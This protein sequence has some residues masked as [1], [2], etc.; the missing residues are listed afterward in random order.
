MRKKVHPVISSFFFLAMLFSFF[1]AILLCYLGSCRITSQLKQ[2][3]GGSERRSKYISYNAFNSRLISDSGRLQVH[4]YEKKLF[5]F[6]LFFRLAS[7]QLVCSRSEGRG[8]QPG[9][10]TSATSGPFA[11]GK[12]SSPARLPAIFLVIEFPIDRAPSARL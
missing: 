4:V 10:S 12:A 8:A 6:F 5:F 2:E 9:L 1:Y 11:P 7:A 3:V